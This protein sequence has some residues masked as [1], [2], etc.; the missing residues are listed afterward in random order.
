MSKLMLSSAAALAVAAAPAFA[1]TPTVATFTTQNV[2]EAL[3]A[4]GITDGTAKKAQNSDGTYADYVA[5][6]YG[7]LKHVASLEVCN[8]T[9]GP[10]CL[11]LN[12]MTI[13][14]DAGSVVD[15][16]KINEF[17]GALPFGKG[18]TAGS[19]LVFQRYAI[20]DGGVS[21][22]Y[23]Q[24]NITNFIGSGQRFQEFVGGSPTTVSASPGD[25]KLA[26]AALTPAEEAAIAALSKE[27]PNKWNAAVTA[28]A[29]E[30]E[31]L[32]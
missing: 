26:K 29:L 12:L 3:N 13:W 15:P 25:A 6:S 2:I 16:R 23:I 1:Q 17:N 10:G 9:A 24:S 32:K 11:G 21:K 7:G 5:F 30:A 14:S 27:F 28:T 20:S 19:A 31:H 8:S 18:F 4:V 22:R